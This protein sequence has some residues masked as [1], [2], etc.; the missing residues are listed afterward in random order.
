[1]KLTNIELQELQSYMEG[2]TIALIGNGKCIL[3]R[4]YGK[5]IDS[6][7]VVIRMNGGAPVKERYKDSVGTK[8]DIYSVNIDTA[9]YIAR[10]KQ[11]KYILRLNPKGKNQLDNHQ[12]QMI[13]TFPNIYYAFGEVQKQIKRLDKTEFINTRPSTGAWT[14]EFLVKNINFKSISLF[15][16]DF[17]GEFRKRRIGNVFN[18]NLSQKHNADS[19]YKYF[20]NIMQNYDIT[21]YYCECKECKLCHRKKLP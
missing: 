20:Q 7:E 1:M 19:E 11:A 5:L 15:G 12:V 14:M 2:K 16:F 13:K 17:F 3:N 4:P 8:L 9:H 10:G 18:S 21:Q 6:H